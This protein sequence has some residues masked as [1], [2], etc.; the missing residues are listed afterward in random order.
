[1]KLHKIILIS[2]FSLIILLV[3]ASAVADDE[4]T[5]ATLEERALVENMRV[6]PM[7]EMAKIKNDGPTPVIPESMIKLNDDYIAAKTRSWDWTFGLGIENYQPHTTANFA[8]VKNYSVD[9]AG[10]TIL[11]SFQF[12]FIRPFSQ[13]AWALG[14]KAK[15]AWIRQSYNLVVPS[16][17]KVDASL[18]S[19]QTSLRPYLKYQLTKWQFQG[20]AENGIYQVNQSSESSL[21]RWT[22]A[23]NFT[24]FFAAV[25]CELSN[26]T[27]VLFEMSSR[28]K[29]KTTVPL[30]MEGQ[31]F[32]LQTEHRW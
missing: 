6:E 32:S 23:V 16:G 2:F 31:T 1:M 26:S 22:Q 12:G 9:S 8:E 25:G 24:G 30:S 17:Q 29:A 18:D 21:A 7:V 3:S 5:T 14:M 20:G 10:S 19:L 15:I 13:S 11:P 27:S 28:E 4:N